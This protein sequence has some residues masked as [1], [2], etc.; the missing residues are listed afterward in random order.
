[1][2]RFNGL[3][4][5]ERRNY[6]HGFGVSLAE[7]H[8][9]LTNMHRIMQTLSVEQGRVGNWCLKETKYRKRKE[10]KQK[11]KRGLSRLLSVTVV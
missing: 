8:I 3:L 2:E 1:M 7:H 11:A 4:K 10:R 5:Q 6:V 9:I